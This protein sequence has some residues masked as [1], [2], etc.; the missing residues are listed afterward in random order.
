MGKSSTQTIGYSYLLGVH[1]A[2]CHGPVDNIQDIRVDDRSI[3]IDVIGP[4]DPFFFPLREDLASQ[5]VIEGDEEELELNR[6]ITE[7]E[8]FK[9]DKPELFGEAEGGIVGDIDFVIGDGEQQPNPYLQGVIEESVPAYNGICSTILKKVN[10]GNN[11][12]IKPWQAKFQRILKR[13]RGDETVDQWFPETAPIVPD[14]ALGG[15]IRDLSIFF[16]VDVSGFAHRTPLSNPGGITP[17]GGRGDI[18]LTKLAVIDT[19]KNIRDSQIFVEETCD[20]GISTISYNYVT[21]PIRNFKK[22]VTRQDLDILI[23]WVEQSVFE[24][25]S[26]PSL[27]NGTFWYQRMGSNLEDFFEFT[28]RTDRTRGHFSVATFFTN[29]QVS[30][31]LNLSKT[32]NTLFQGKGRSFTGNVLIPVFEGQSSSSQYISTFGCISDANVIANVIAVGSSFL[33]E[34]PGSTRY[35]T[36][37]IPLSGNF[38]DIN[39]DM[40]PAHIVR[41]CLT[42]T[43]WGLGLPESDIDDV[44]FTQ[45]ANTLF[46]ENFGISLAWKQQTSLEDFIQN[47]LNHADMVLYVRRDTGLW[48]LKL[49]REDYNV[50][51]LEI[52][53]DDDIVEWETLTRRSPSELIN[54]VT[55]NYNDRILR[56]SASLTVN[57]LAQVQQLGVVIP[58]TVNYPGIWRTDLASRVAERDLRA[59]SSQVITGEIKLTRRANQLYPGDVFR[60]SSQR[61]GL[62]GEVFRVL[63]IDIGDG[64]QN[65]VTVKFSQDVFTLSEFPTVVSPETEFV[66]PIQDVRPAVIDDS[67]I[68][69]A[70]YYTLV[71]NFGDRN[72]DDL[73]EDE[74]ELGLVAA[75]AVRPDNSSINAALH[76]DQG[77]ANFERT[78]TLSYIPFAELQ[79]DLPFGPSFDTFSISELPSLSRVRLNQ[80]IQVGY[81]LMRITDYSPTSLSV[82][83]G[84]LDTIPQEHFTGD[85]VYFWGGNEEVVEQEF[86]KSDVVKGRFRSLYPSTSLPIQRAPTVTT[87]IEG[88]AI[89]PY[90][91]GNIQLN[92][93]YD[94][95]QIWEGTLE[96]TWSHRDRTLETGNTPPGYFDGDIGP[97]QNSTYTIRGIDVGLT[98]EDTLFEDTGITS[99][100]GSVDTTAYNPAG[101]GVRVLVKTVRDG[102]ESRSD[103]PYFSSI[104]QE[105]EDLVGIVGFWIDANDEST[106]FSDVEKT[107]NTNDGES[108]ERI[109]NLKG[110]IL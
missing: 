82:A 73:L 104:I 107:T 58:T 53:T 12:Y 55:V 35:F 92:G 91:P 80:V 16:S 15:E 21:S 51:N 93:S 39:L 18:S 14:D 31:A 30:D 79:E 50:D 4:D 64:R 101:Y 105:P 10:L 40:N 36:S 6:V 25:D 49:I 110:I 8:E 109:K 83:R 46:Q 9:I 86:V 61:Y 66:D 102:Y 5:G 100:S 89:K 60:I 63:E 108:V 42:D 106:V 54:S 88:R 62:T 76:L 75:Y 95:F 22:D 81:E 56:G 59:L 52:F 57:N 1:Q 47:V 77:T 34:Q 68:F 27:C 33:Q 71:R 3:L 44:S 69:E 19:L 28:G 29:Q 97:E 7:S 74:P 26:T 38:G 23:E 84:I 85:K 72:I 2:W 70:P 20:I 48:T 32:T 96:V 67:A 45:V 37:L 90:R 103:S 98:F 11:P 41:E 13:I 24:D 99:S 94:N 65:E 87:E 17:L 78:A 43:Y